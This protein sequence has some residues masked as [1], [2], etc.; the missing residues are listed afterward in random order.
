MVGL[1]VM[2][3]CDTVLISVPS[4]GIYPS[5]PSVMLAHRFSVSESSQ[6]HFWIWVFALNAA[7]WLTLGFLF[8]GLRRKP[9]P[10]K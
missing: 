4:I 10:A 1:V 6:R 3:W 7:I 8:S 5:Y 2:L 9:A